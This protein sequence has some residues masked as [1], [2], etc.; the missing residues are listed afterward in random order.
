MGPPVV[1]HGLQSAFMER[2]LPHPTN[3]HS[4]YKI[5]GTGHWLRYPAMEVP[6]GGCGGF[7]AP[8]LHVIGP[9]PGHV[10]SKCAMCAGHDMGVSPP[11][12]LLSASN[13][14]L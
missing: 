6:W 14:A 1:L 11:R 8:P 7:G 2:P 9:M 13:A 4:S 10:V 5:H 12:L 3:T